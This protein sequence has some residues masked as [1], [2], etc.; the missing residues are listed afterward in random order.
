MINTTYTTRIAETKFELE[1][2]CRLNHQTFSEELEQHQKRENGML[3][4]KFHA[5]NRYI[6]CWKGDELVG[7]AAVRDVRPF[8][9]DS[10]IEN[11]DSY[12][13]TFDTIVEMRLFAVKPEYRRTRV[14]FLVL[15]AM[16][17][18]LVKKKYDMA[19]ISGILEQ[20]E[21]YAKFGF[22][23][24]GP[25][26]GTDRAK[27]Q[28]M[29]LSWTNLSKSKHLSILPYLLINL[30]PGPVDIKPNIA[31]EYE[32]YPRHHRSDAFIK[33]YDLI[34]SSISKMMNVKNT[35][36]FTGS[37]T[38]ANEV[39]LAHIST[40]NL[41]GA[42]LSNGEFGNRLI[43]QAKRFQLK[44]SEYIIPLITRI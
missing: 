13:P 27:F 30:S 20:Q 11:L 16:V 26:L 44:F 42:I 23:P 5:E 17:F 43:L 35:Q 15:N 8:S 7:M 19:V 29:Y 12:L 4:D 33:K 24:F 25:I 14:V 18:E 21:L 9:L 34:C 2:V 6:T 22:V 1:E 40:L 28:P 39:I 37:G 36:I 41:D 32:K 3:I 31:A 38:L 10:K